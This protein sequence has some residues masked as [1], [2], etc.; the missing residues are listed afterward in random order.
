MID[1]LANGF[2]NSETED[3]LV[4]QQVKGLTCRHLVSENRILIAD[5]GFNEEL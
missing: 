3:H 4:P 2:K 5:S 1:L